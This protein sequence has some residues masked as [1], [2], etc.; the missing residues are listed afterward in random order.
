MQVA[1]KR[2]YHLEK[3]LNISIGIGNMIVEFLEKY[4]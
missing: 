1:S 2:G 4:K 3:D